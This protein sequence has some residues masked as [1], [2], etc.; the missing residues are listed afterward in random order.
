TSSQDDPGANLRQSVTLT[1][2]ASD[3][4]GS[5][6]TSVAFQRR[7]SG[8]GSWTTIATDGTFPYSTSFDTTGVADGLY[9]FRAVAT[10]TAGNAEASPV[11][12]SSR[13][14][15]NTAPSAT[16]LT[17]GDPVRGTVTLTSSMSDAGSGI[18]GVSYELAPHG[19]SFNSQPS[20]WDTTLSPDGLY[21]LRVTATDIAGNTTTSSLIT[22]RV[23][24][25][26][27]ALT[28]STPASGAV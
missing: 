18:A 17:P 24:N 20:T 19:G 9:D 13:R 2:S 6:I 27:P 25:T 7:P 28:F 21:D 14:I 5:G 12:V 22:T 8:S 11:V 10:D 4:G 26:A 3:T 16:M 15:D 23:D 1:A